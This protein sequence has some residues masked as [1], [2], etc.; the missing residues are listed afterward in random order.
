[1]SL[2]KAAVALKGILKPVPPT[3]KQQELAAALGVTQQAVSSWLRGITQP[4]YEK[5][6][7]IADLLGVPIEDWKV[8]AVGAE[9]SGPV[10]ALDAAADPDAL[11][12]T[13]S[14]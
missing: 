1:M 14:S 5:R 7:K 4:S 3:M 8:E 11:T 13:D 2:S 10:P 6:M 12:G 9:D